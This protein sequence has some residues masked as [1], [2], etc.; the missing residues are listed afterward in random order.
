MD[1]SMY[2]NFS[3]CGGISPF[4][5]D[6]RVFATEDSFV[7]T[8]RDLKGERS[9]ERILAAPGIPAEWFRNE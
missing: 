1:P 7:P 3:S 9:P 8:V 4:L 2:S 5:L 6:V